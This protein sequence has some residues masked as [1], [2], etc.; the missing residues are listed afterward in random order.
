MRTTIDAAGRVAIPR[1]LRDE[2]GYAP[3]TELVL[4]AVNGRLELSRPSR[5]RVEAG[6]HGL[7]FVA[8]DAEPLR[9]EDVRALV[10]DLRERPVL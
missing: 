1:S 3:G 4:R 9:P 7:R 5:V 6:P 8:D 2:L 10:D